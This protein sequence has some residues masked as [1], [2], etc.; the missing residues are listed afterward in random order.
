MKSNFRILLISK[1]PQHV[2]TLL[3]THP[4]SNITIILDIAE[5]LSELVNPVTKDGI[6]AILLHLSQPALY[7]AL[8]SLRKRAINLPVIAL[9]LPGEEDAWARAIKEGA[10]NYLFENTMDMD[11]LIRSVRFAAESCKI[12]EDLRK[13]NLKIMEHEK[14]IIEIERLNGIID[15]YGSEAHELNQPL[16]ALLGSIYL[17][18]LDR[19]DPE[20]ISRHVER[21]DDSGRRISAIVKNIQG[22]RYEKYNCYL[23]NGSLK[24]PDQKTKS[25]I[26]ITDNNFEDLNNLFRTVQARCNR[27]AA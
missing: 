22:M 13:A 8:E 26:E 18:K 19:D 15:Q 16:T 24:N 6:D 9:I 4:G 17:M 21:I 11:S 1:N 5:T 27:Q 25:N 20:K 2:Q 3:N 12:T 14:F 10:H 7:E 23:G